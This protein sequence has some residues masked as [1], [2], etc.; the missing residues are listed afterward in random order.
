MIKG[1]VVSSSYTRTDHHGGG[2]LIMTKS[3]INGMERRDLVNLSVEMVCEVAAVEIISYSLVIVAIYRPPS[4]DFDVF[5]NRM[6]EILDILSNSCK[7]VIIVGD[8]NVYFNTLSNRTVLLVDILNSY[9]FTQHILGNTR[10]GACLDN[11]FV[12][13]NE[14]LNFST[15]IVDG[16][17]SDHQAVEIQVDMMDTV[18]SIDTTRIMYRPLTQHGINSMFQI[19]NQADW[20]FLQSSCSANPKANIFMDIFA[21]AL[22]TSFPERGRTVRRDHHISWFNNDL[23]VM[24]DNL[25][26]LNSLSKTY[27]LPELAAQARRYRCHYRNAINKAKKEANSRFIQ[28][29]DSCIKAAW[30][31]VNE[32]RGACRGGDLPGNITA[33]DF[34]IF[35]SNIAEE[36]LRNIPH[37]K[38]KAENFLKQQNKIPTDQGFHF[39]EVTYVKVRDAINNLKNKHS[40]DIY[41]VSVSL[42]KKIKDT[43]IIPLTKLL[44][45]CINEGVY[46][47]CFKIS[48]VIPV[49]K[50]GD[51]AEVN[52]YR[53]ISLIPALSKVFEY[54]LKDQLLSYFEKNSILN[55]FQYGFR[56]GKSTTLALMDLLEYVV[57]GF[58]DGLYIGATLCDLSKAFDCISHDILLT[59]LRYYG[60]N[61]LSLELMKSYLIGRKQQTSTGGVLS[62][63]TS[64]DH[65]VPQ[66]SILGPLL[67]IIYVNDI[68]NSTEQKLVLFADDTTALC[69]R[70]TLRELDSMM[71]GVV[72]ELNDWFAANKLSLNINKTEKILF[73]LRDL[74]PDDEARS[75]A[76][77]F[78]GVHLDTTLVFE[79]HINVV[80]K[81]ITKAIFLLKNLKKT[82]DNNVVLMVFHALVQSICNYGLLAWGHAPQAERVFKLQRRA[83]RAVEG[84]NYRADVR[85]VFK[86]LNVLTLPCRYILDCLSYIKKNV[87]RYN[88]CSDV[89]AYETRQADNVYINFLRLKKSSIATLYYAPKFFNKLPR[90]MRFLSE[91][92]FILQVKNMLCTNAFYSFDEFLLAEL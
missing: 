24:R 50:K 47:D 90:T 74:G 88:L 75:D 81:K 76:V 17:S 32:Q 78:L 8:F 9:G 20:S 84:L 44:N 62:G 16:V 67:F 87:N 34:N 42:L 43:L 48:K 56:K 38:I 11:I 23:K 57:E 80:S 63:E 1:Y 27:R 26:F 52:N 77:R 12:N 31:V 40:K 72:S 21:N 19:L 58:E 37:V 4:G 70:E 29:A 69:R 66:G 71:T 82:V 5:L 25:Q 51:R 79:E 10:Q 54:L 3:E 30:Q 18:A 45:F 86:K 64:V 61:D 83:L 6:N 49:Y 13:F 55:N 60:L 15:D 39:K 7:H 89:H 33:S 35:F 46:P 92:D 65:G 59:K 41:E 22:K 73:S 53:P 2:V 14:I 85:E 36:T 91:K 68:G 28:Q